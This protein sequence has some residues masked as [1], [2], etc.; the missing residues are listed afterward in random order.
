M[1]YVPQYGGLTLATRANATTVL[2]LSSIQ[3][4]INSRKYKNCNVSLHHIACIHGT[5]A[6][7]ITF[8]LWCLLYEPQF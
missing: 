4:A 3:V 7:L 2:H 1:D 5:L 8:T 6:Q